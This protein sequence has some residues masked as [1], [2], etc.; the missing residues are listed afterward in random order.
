MSLIFWAK[1][2]EGD[3]CEFYDITPE[4][5]FEGRNILNTKLP[6]KEFANQRHTDLQ[7]LKNEINREKKLLWKARESRKHPLKDDK[8]LSGWNGLM[9]WSLS[10]AGKAFGEE[11]YFQAAEKAALFIQENLWQ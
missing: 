6:I 3:F 8:I 1:S 7:D 5:N 9:I 11:K 2:N 4:G 10:E